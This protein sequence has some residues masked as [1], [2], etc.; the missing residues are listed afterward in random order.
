MNHASTTTAAVILLNRL[1]VGWYFIVAGWGKIGME[2]SGGLGSFYMSDGFQGRN[3]DWLP[4]L[5]AAPYGYA[6]P[7]A[8][9]ILGAMLL[10]G[11]FGRATAGMLAVIAVSIAIAL[12]GAGQLLPSH[13]VMVF[14]PL[15]LWL[16]VAGSGRYSVDAWWSGSTAR[17]EQVGGVVQT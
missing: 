5:I 3:P 7:W 14:V 17:A 2:L 15:L 16:A 13:H 11:L 4:A 1:A 6:L 10:V 12:L 8:E 9:L